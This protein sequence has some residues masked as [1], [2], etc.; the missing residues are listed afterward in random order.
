M[1]VGI[2]QCSG[3]S[4]LTTALD[5]FSF[6]KIIYN[7]VHRSVKAT[8]KNNYKRMDIKNFQTI[9][10]NQVECVSSVNRRSETKGDY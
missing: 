7:S 10:R 2:N 5:E 8:F 3:N 4:G 1:I 6:D 9:Y